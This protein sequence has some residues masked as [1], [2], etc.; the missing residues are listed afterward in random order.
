MNRAP[1]D[2]RNG[3]MSLKF[4][5]AVLHSWRFRHAIC[6]TLQLDFRAVELRQVAIYYG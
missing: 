1:M 4:Q 6:G 2:S 5:P 3:H